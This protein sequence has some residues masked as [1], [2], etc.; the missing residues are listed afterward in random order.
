MEEWPNPD[1]DGLEAALFYARKGWRV[2]PC[3]GKIPLVKEW[4]YNATDDPE[5]IEE[6]FDQYPDSWVG[7]LCSVNSGRATID[8]D[9]K[10]GG[11]ENAK[12]LA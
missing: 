3:R 2:H 11:M 12:K 7:L 10:N 8:I 4:Q 6:W 5:Q 1:W 9:K